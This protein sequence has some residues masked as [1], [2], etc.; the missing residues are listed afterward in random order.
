MRRRWLPGAALLCL[1]AVPAVAYPD[2]VAEQAK[3][4]G[5]VVRVQS[6]DEL[7]ANVRYLAGLVGQEE[8]AKQIE[9]FLKSMAG[10]KGLE[11]IDTKRPIGLYGNF[12]PNGID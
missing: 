4:P 1:I 6:I 5:L 3:K 9:G 10:P 12:G 8:Q 11:G 2:S 7:L